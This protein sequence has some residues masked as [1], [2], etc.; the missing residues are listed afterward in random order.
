M[1]LSTALL[2]SISLKTTHTATTTTIT[3]T[4]TV[5]GSAMSTTVTSAASSTTSTPSPSAKT[6]SSTTTM[7][8]QILSSHR[9]VV[10]SAVRHNFH[11]VTLWSIVT[12]WRTFFIA[13]T[14]TNHFSTAV[15]FK[16]TW[17]CIRANN[18][19]VRYVTNISAG[20]TWW[21]LTWHELTV[22]PPLLLTRLARLHRLTRPQRLTIGVRSNEGLIKNLNRPN[23]KFD[24]NF[25]KYLFEINSLIH[26][27]RMSFEPCRNNQG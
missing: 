12:L 2:L 8:Q 7:T 14:V 27:C 21:K 11:R 23:S 20:S 13:R 4:A 25:L 22:D 15:G 6:S 5:S 3:T 17:V 19:S 24:V 16:D 18:T 10:T 1:F 26:D 9:Q